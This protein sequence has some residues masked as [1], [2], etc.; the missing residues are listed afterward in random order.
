MHELPSC[1]TTSQLHAYE[2]FIFSHTGMTVGVGKHYK[3][4]VIVVYSYWPP[5]D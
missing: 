4:A 1:V 3:H 5:K 2:H